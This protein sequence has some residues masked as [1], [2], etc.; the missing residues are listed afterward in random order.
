MNTK[1]IKQ[2]FKLMLVMIVMVTLLPATKVKA[3][4]KRTTAIDLTQLN[5]TEDPSVNIDKLT[6]EGWAWYAVDTGAYTAK[7]IVLNGL[8]LDVT[9]DSHSIYL[10]Y[11]DRAAALFL[12]DGATI[13]VEGDS[14]IKGPNSVSY[15]SA[16]IISIG[17][18]SV[19]GPGT[20]NVYGGE[21]TSSSN[22]SFSLYAHTDLTID[23]NI[24]AVASNSDNSSYGIFAYGNITI[25][26][27][28][29]YAKA[30]DVTKQ[31][32]SPESN[33]VRY[34]NLY[35][36]DGKLTTQSGVVMLN[37]I[38]SP[39]YSYVL[40]GFEINNVS[41]KGGADQTEYTKIPFSSDGW[42]YGM[43]VNG[44]E[45]FPKYAVVR[46]TSVKLDIEEWL[47]ENNITGVTVSESTMNSTISISGT[48]S[49]TA[50]TTLDLEIPN[51][52][53]VRWLTNLTS[54]ASPAINILDTSGTGTNFEFGG[55]GTLTCTG[56]YAIH[57]KA[58]T[59]INVQSGKLVSTADAAVYFEKSTTLKGDNSSVIF[60][61]GDNIYKTLDS[62]VSITID[63]P[64]LLPI[65]WDGLK[66]S[67]D[68]GSSEG[69]SF[70]MPSSHLDDSVQWMS[71]SGKNIVYFK[72][73]SFTGIIEIPVVTVTPTPTA[74]PT[75]QANESS[76]EHS[77]YAYVDM[78]GA[79]NGLKN[80]PYLSTNFGESTNYTYY[81]NTSDK[82]WDGTL[83]TS[84]T[85]LKPGT[86]YIYA[87][88]EELGNT[89]GTTKF[90][91]SN[92]KYVVPN[93]GVK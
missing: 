44:V 19:E 42:R 53:K 59:V 73:G 84:K 81:Y 18:L 26:G 82:N 5:G 2:I 83:W 85:V 64:S 88:V 43:T 23:C 65:L 71:L 40:S 9:D 89:T 86:Y 69:L 91:V 60:A 25:N 45:T 27:G 74:T 8:D 55:G 76:V 92:G 36:I 46:P 22:S 21:T 78:S 56:G 13:I 72:I 32:T 7:T 70:Y 12:P 6:D 39:E 93:T 68:D 30:G 14:T 54:S 77:N 52:Y 48:S 63:F 33:A 29:I 34:T 67:Y 4:T 28:N 3:A 31:G 17:N 49:T 20:L 47:D 79:N 15:S 10:F 1:K 51:G 57:N 37:G 11:K 41:V 66:T 16:G 38:F 87:Y 90:V 62:S 58:D 75:P 80:V 50:T 24:N 61:K 35:F